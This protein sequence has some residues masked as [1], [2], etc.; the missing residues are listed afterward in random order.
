MA[1]RILITGAG[2]LLGRT[3]AER[4]RSS[5]LPLEPAF[6]G[7]V[8]VRAVTHAEL[9]V[10]RKLRID[11]VIDEFKPD[12]VF[13]AAGFTNVDLC[14]FHK[15]KAYLVNRDGAEHIAKATQRT[16]A[17]DVYFS[18]DFVFDGEKMAPY[19]E[20]DPPNPL[21][22]YGDTKLAGELGTMSHSTRHLIIRGG[23]LFGEGGHDFVSRVLEWTRTEEVIFG[24]EDE[25]RQPTYVKDFVDAVLHLVAGGQTGIYHV[26]NGGS[27]TES[28]LAEKLIAILG[29]NRIKVKG[30][31][32]D[33]AE[34][35]ALR[36]RYSVLKCAKLEAAG[37]RP[38][39]WEEALREFLDA[40]GD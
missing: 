28:R 9:D 12:I 6:S 17:L 4:C 1:T 30:M 20:E 29:R 31:N 14:E 33:T 34:L 16:G 19:V 8:E 36:P 32:R 40:A 15:W 3:L 24:Y 26:A 38:R 11:E 10:S 22:I 35:A 37:H 39:G 5:D 21:S 23:W 18:T 13:N 2:G 27:T 7:P 25:V